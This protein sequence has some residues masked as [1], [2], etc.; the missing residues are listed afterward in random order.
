MII[1]SIKDYLI[2]IVYRQLRPRMMVGFKVKGKPKDYSIRIGS[3]THIE[4]PEYFYPQSDIFIGHYNF[5]EA[6]NSIY[7]GKFCQIT[8]YVSILTHSSHIAIRLHNSDYSSTRNH[9]G[10]IR[11]S[12]E[13][14]DYTFVGPHTV[15]MPGSKIGK[16]CIIK[17]FSFVRGEFPDY[18]IIGGNPASVIGDTREL[19]R[20][21][22]DSHP[23]LS[24]NYNKNISNIR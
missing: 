17:A 16:A 14:G 15:I 3:T 8:N 18:S 1:N 12:V 11:G 10:Y 20:P 23:Q 13:I 5:I 2:K 19:D 4:S 22:L 24:A 6:S 21:F 7:I 9:I